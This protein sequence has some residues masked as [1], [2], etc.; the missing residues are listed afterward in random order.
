MKMNQQDLINLISRYLDNALPAEET[1]R[2]LEAVR[3]DAAAAD[4]MCELSI[5]HVQLHRLFKKDAA[6]E[7]R[8][9]Y[10]AA[11]FFSRLAPSW[12]PLA[13]AACLVLLVAAGF[14]LAGMMRE[15]YTT[16]DAAIVLL[17]IGGDTED[18]SEA[19]AA[20]DG[21][22]VVVPPGTIQLLR[23]R[24][25]TFIQLEP[26]SIAQI[27]DDGCEG[28]GKSCKIIKLTSGMLMADVARQPDNFPLRVLT[29]HT[30]IIVAGTRLTCK[31]ENDHTHVRMHDGWAHVVNAI[32]GAKTNLIARH[33]ITVGESFHFRLR[34]IHEDAH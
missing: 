8:R 23:F 13:I 32:N 18:T 16:P 9:E 4:L 31:A 15:R 7:T 1:G 27:V 26:G 14:W 20:S 21:T 12:R 24:D 29:P 25:G 17:K 11:T 28:S 22:T 3:A 33:H 10:S 34:S 2:L 19:K 30:E 5:Q 6:A